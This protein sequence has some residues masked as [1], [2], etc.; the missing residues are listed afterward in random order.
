[1]GLVEELVRSARERARRIVVREP[2]GKPSGPSL[3]V[4]LRGKHCL[5]VIA[6]FKRKSPSLGAIAEPDIDEQVRRYEEAGAAAISV[7]TEPTRFGGSYED[8]SR[9][10]HSVEA[11]V[12]MKDF[13]VDPVQVREA[14]RLGARAVLLI[15]RCLSEADLDELVSACAHYGLTPLLECHRASEIEKALRHDA[16]VLG[17]NN[18]DLETLEIDRAL[19]PRL[20]AE[21]PGDRVAVAESGYEKAED[22]RGLRGLADAV[23]VGSALMRHQDPAKLVKLIGEIRG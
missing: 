11:P 20:L 15:L 14:A 1:M 8:L 5:D 19:A 13:V 12:L 9:A 7:L 10:V 6:E 21:V 17:A 18:R 23:L 2:E 22:V 16:A 4:V 3:P